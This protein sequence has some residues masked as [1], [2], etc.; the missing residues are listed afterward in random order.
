[1]GCFFKRISARL[2]LR[3]V[4]VDEDNDEDDT[5]DGEDAEE[6]INEDDD[7]SCKSLIR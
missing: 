5:E 1:M 6:D 3:R 4:I 2:L 7:T